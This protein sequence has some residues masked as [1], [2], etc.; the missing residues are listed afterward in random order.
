MDINK[1]IQTRKSVKYFGQKKPDWRNIIQAIDAA[2]YAPMAG[3]LFNLKFILVDN[4]KKIEELSEA[5]QQN[6]INQAKY[7]VV[8]CSDPS[9][10]SNAYPEKG[11]K[12]TKQQAGAAIENFL[13]KLNE[14]NL[15]TCWVGHFV[16]DQIKHALEIPEKI[17]VEAIFPIGYESKKHKTK[18]KR[19][20]NLDSV[21]YFNKY[22][23]KR[24]K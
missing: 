9:R 20:T 6:F 5:A 22:K 3:N 21:L 7:V 14:R 23:Q 17:D 11:E 18:P 15:A 4:E 19:K 16:E 10:T 1:T 24:M 8:I 12:Y 13:L 2:R